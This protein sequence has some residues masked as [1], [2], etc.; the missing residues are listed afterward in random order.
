M[1]SDI[2]IDQLP[3]FTGVCL[4]LVVYCHNGRLACFWV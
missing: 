3:V 2:N 1:G 4:T